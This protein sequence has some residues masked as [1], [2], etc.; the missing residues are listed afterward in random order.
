MRLFSKKILDEETQLKKLLFDVEDQRRGLLRFG[1]SSMRI[2][3]CLPY[4][5]PRFS[6]EYP[7]VQLEVYSSC[8]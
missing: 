1:A 4:I 6:Q 5:L 8:F 3:D 7:E 2:N